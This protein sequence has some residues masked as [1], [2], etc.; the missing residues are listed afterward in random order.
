MRS[1]TRRPFVITPSQGNIQLAFVLKLNLKITLFNFVRKRSV[2]TWRNGTLWGLHK[3]KY[4]VLMQVMQ[5]LQ[6]KR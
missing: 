2:P 1:S 6:E 3:P 4:T 5:P